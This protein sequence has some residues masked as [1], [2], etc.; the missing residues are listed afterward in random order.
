MLNFQIEATYLSKY[1]ALGVIAEG[2]RNYP[3]D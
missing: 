1:I 2:S 3:K